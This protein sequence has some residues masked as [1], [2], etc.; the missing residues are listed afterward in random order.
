MECDEFVVFLQGVQSHDQASANA[1][2]DMLVDFGDGIDQDTGSGPRCRAR[3]DY[4][5]ESSEDLTFLEGE[6][7]KLLEHVGD[8]WLRG[9]LN[10]KSGI[11]PATFVEV[12]E[13]LPATPGSIS[14]DSDWTTRNQSDNSLVREAMY[15][16]HGEDAE[17]SF[18]VSFIG[19]VKT[20]E[21]AKEGKMKCVL[22][23]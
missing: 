22:E 7:I 1:P 5:G 17:L 15:T 9:E 19:L 3:F 8:D 20:S 21:T 12:I 4:D 10:G 13:D 2:V 16:F 23:S 11:F 6:I 18:K 14:G